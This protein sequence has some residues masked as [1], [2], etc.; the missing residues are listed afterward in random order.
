MGQIIENQYLSQSPLQIFSIFSN[1]KC[2]I[3]LSYFSSSAF[4]HIFF[5]SP[6]PRQPNTIEF[7]ISFF[8]YRIGIS[9]F[10]TQRKE[11]SLEHFSL[12]DE[13]MKFF[14]WFIY[15]VGREEGAEFNNNERPCSWAIWLPCCEFFW[16]ILVK[17]ESKVP[18]EQMENQIKFSVV[19][20]GSIYYGMFVSKIENIWE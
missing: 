13:N 10:I 18:T 17:G 2:S 19:R 4:L 14:L 3:N 12:F 8:F 5:L 20:F 11:N 15:L 16:I 9:F 1:S 7:A 6:W